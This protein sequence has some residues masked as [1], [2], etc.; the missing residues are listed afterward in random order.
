M[1]KLPWELIYMILQQ[2]KEISQE[3]RIKKLAARYGVKL[4]SIHRHGFQVYVGS[5]VRVIP[6]ERRL[7]W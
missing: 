1:R 3:I 7:F 4:K 2:R 5:G 6:L